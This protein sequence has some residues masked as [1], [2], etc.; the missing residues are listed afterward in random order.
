MPVGRALLFAGLLCGCLGN[1]DPAA[2]QARPRPAPPT[3]APQAP[4]RRGHA[5]HP[6]LRPHGIPGA[7][8]LTLNS[9]FSGRKLDTAV[10]RPGWFGSGITGPLSKHETACYSDHHVRVSHGTV[11][12]TVTRSRSRCGG[13]TRPYTGAVL[14][15]NPRDGRR[16]GGFTYRYGVLEARVFLPSADRSKVADW[17]GV[18]GLG[19]IWPRNGE[20]DILENLDGVVC[21]RWHSPG[22]AP[23]GNL[24]ACH[25][26]FT[27]GWHIVS[28]NW[29]PGSVTWYYD[30]I[31][32]AH[33]SRGITSDPMYIV[34]VNTTSIKA[35]GVAKPDT[36]RV[37]YV[38]VWQRAHAGH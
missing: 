1:L 30:G 32:V 15:T 13:E 35:P 2:A 27:P 16:R 22:F 12:M 8:K 36:M 17:P 28:S 33:A 5:S 21:S 3:T 18:V 24:G 14:S 9:D 26:G 20:D 4:H 7:W 34:L 37:G 29:E 25:P 6:G 38:R 19:Y 31:E 10:W 11:Q 23:G